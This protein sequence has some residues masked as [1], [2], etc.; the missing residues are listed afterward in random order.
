MLNAVK[1][2]ILEMIILARRAADQANRQADTYRR[3]FH[4]DKKCAGTS[5]FTYLLGD[6]SGPKA[7][8]E[9]PLRIVYE[10]WVSIPPF[11][12]PCFATAARPYAMCVC[13]QDSP[14]G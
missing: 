13:S 9:R 11:S 8:R 2:S 7:M 12:N 3:Y 4:P 5:V 14:P 6:G 10:D 1:S